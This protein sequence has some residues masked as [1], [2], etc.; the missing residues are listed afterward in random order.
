MTKLTNCGALVAA[1]PALV[2]TAACAGTDATK[3]SSENPPAASS[4]ASASSGGGV[5]VTPQN[6]AAYKKAVECVQAQGVALPEPKVGEPFSLA[7]MNK[8]AM[9]PQWNKVLEA[10]PDY[11][12]VIILG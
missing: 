5:T 3:V 6:L 9:T 10:C 12:K 11:T 7:E 1:L 8:I 2:L 4:S